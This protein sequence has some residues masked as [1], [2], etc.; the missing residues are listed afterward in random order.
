MNKLL[1]DELGD[2][3][4][5]SLRVG[6]PYK[7]GTRKAMSAT[8]YIRVDVA[9]LG[10]GS[11]SPRADAQVRDHSRKESGM[12]PLGFAFVGARIRG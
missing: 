5:R 11:H 6:R 10:R 9:E 1:R 3:T 7:K 2:V 4:F 12:H 8:L